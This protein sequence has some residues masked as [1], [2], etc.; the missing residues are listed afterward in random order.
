MRVNAIRLG[1]VRICLALMLALLVVPGYVVAPVLFA[2]AGSV[3]LAGK[4]AGDIFHMANIGIIF[5]TAAVLVFWL[6][7]QKGGDEA[8]ALEI[9]RLRWSLLLALLLLVMINEYGISPIIMDIKAQIAQIGAYDSLPA[10]NPLRQRFGMWH[11]ISALVHLAASL[12]AVVLVAVGA[13]R[14]TAV[15]AQADDA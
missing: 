9:G 4:L 7:M 5:L 13:A 15:A 12:V 14:T 3:T 10:E 6:R 1:S 11:G 2:H 8:A